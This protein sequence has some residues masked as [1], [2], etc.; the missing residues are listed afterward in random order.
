LISHSGVQRFCYI[1]ESVS[2]STPISA[3]P[4][5][6]H[7]AS[8]AQPSKGTKRH[9]LAALFSAT[10]PGA[11][12]LFLGQRRKAITLLMILATLLICF[13][14]LRFPRFYAAFVLLCWGWIALYVY[15]A[16]SALLARNLQTE[17]RP[18]RWWLVATVPVTLL[19]LGFSGAAVA[20]ASGFRSFSIPSPSME[21]TLLK[22]DQIVADMRYYRSRSPEHRDVIIFERDRTFF[23]KR[24]IATSSDTIQGSGGDVFV[25]GQK[26]VEPYVQHTSR[27]PSDWMVSFG[28]VKVGDGKYFVMG[29]NRDV[30]LD[31]RWQAFGLVSK[32]SV[33]GKPLY[34]LSSS[35]LGK[36][37]Q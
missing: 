36:H 24:V 3:L 5:A 15:A 33:A 9:L 35:R 14:P 29:D 4:L 23:V 30:S 27:D 25:N 28:P 21:N 6:S 1:A 7:P 8:S 11:G 22:G 2:E 31:S 37:V 12:Q 18:S 34:V 17:V 10:A 32:D 16:C 13:W 20:R 19:T 26:I